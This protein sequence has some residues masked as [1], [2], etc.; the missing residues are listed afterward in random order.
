MMPPLPHVPFAR[1]RASRSDVAR[2]LLERA[3]Q[4]SHLAPFH[5]DVNGDRGVASYR[6][7]SGSF[8]LQVRFRRVGDEW[9]EGE[10][11]VVP[12]SVVALR[13][14][15][16]DVDPAAV[17]RCLD[18]TPSRAFGKGDIGP[19]GRGVRD[20]GLWIH[21][22]LPDAC[23][24]AEEKIA[25]LL[26]MLRGRAGWA[27]VLGLRGVTWAGITVK[28]RCPIERPSGIALEPRVLEDFAGL[29]LAFDLEL[30]NE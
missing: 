15:L 1:L 9:Q 2:P 13:L 24:F 17:T 12:G 19:L 3:P 16:D 7:Q 30:M 25:E 22:V 10:V 14:V 26:A 28:L 8:C 21:E 18:L 29:S 23:C 6:T 4:W 27:R 11:D 20:E 5:S